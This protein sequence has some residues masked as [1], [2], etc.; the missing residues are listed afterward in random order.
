[1]V[2]G[3]PPAAPTWRERLVASDPGSVR[4]V[5]AVRAVLAIVVVGGALAG[6]TALLGLSGTPGVVTIVLGVVLAMVSTFTVAD[7][8]PGGRLVTQLCLP[9]AMLA[10]VVLSSLLDT[11]RAPSLVV[12]VLLMVAVVWARRFGPRAF[13]AGMVAW[14][15]YFVTLFLQLRPAMLGLAV[16]GIATATASLLV[17]LVVVP[18]RPARRLRRMVSSLAA[19]VRIARWEAPRPG[20]QA[21]RGA[22]TAL[23]R[24]N[25]A[26]VLVDGQLA[27]R[28]AVRRL[29]SA[30]AVRAAV[31]R[32]ELALAAL[33]ED[34]RIE[35]SRE[36]DAALARLDEVL[37]ADR[38]GHDV[39]RPDT[40]PDREFTPGAWL[41]GGFL[42]GSAVT[43]GTMFGPDAGNAG[44]SASSRLPLTSRQALQIGLASALAIVLGLLVSGQR[45]YWAVLACFLA[46]TG[47]A[48][49]A[50]TAIK[51]GQRVL[52]TAVGVALALL[53]VPLLGR[54]VPV[55]LGVMLVALFLGFYLF[56]ISYTM[57]ALAVTVMVAE[58]YQLMGTYS[59]GLLLLRVGETLLGAVVGGAVAMTFL[60][61]PARRAESA[62][63]VQLAEALRDALVDV[64]AVVRDHGGR[65]EVTAA[66]LHERLRALDAGVHQLALIGG[67]LVRRTLPG[68][69]ARAAPVQ[70]RLAAWIGCAIRVRAVVHAVEDA[71]VDGAPAATGPDRASVSRALGAVGE[72][73]EGL[74]VGE[75]PAGSGR[76]G[77]EHDDAVLHEVAALHGAVV[78][79]HEI[80]T[81]A[82]GPAPVEAAAPGLARLCG[83]VTGA[84][85]AL[86]D[87]VVT[88]I[89]P[90]GRQHGRTRATGGRYELVL[91]GA[92]TWQLVV[93]APGHAPRADRLVVGERSRVVVHDL[94]LAPSRVRT[95]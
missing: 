60:P 18:A 52:G 37:A 94:V 8:T 71:L 44:D 54:S 48:T 56:R 83:A 86:P 69:D 53:M 36:V 85:G 77:A 30:S 91:P 10:A 6:I 49:A 3:T 31:L 50:E 11:Y 46:F 4:L 24:V 16:L 67:P 9:A 88:L 32:V 73:A 33:L 82:P 19:R 92:G 58:L 17:L 95:R 61:T 80:D 38:E 23:L 59:E 25:E 65:A 13:A 51:A 68:R 28:G 21:R 57:L 39:A 15:G 93:G 5:L 84:D 72:L 41:F 22:S 14:I 47:T 70:R 45:W 87:A 62:A 27:I 90:H 78:A 26:A 63:R 79:L 42:P 66:D 35:A 1:M 34:G 55:V 7:P 20:R 74:L 76:V 75:A 43:V 89:D 64:S 29:S 2:A 40:P 12:F 81:A